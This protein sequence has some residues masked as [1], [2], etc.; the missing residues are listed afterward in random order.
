MIIEPWGEVLAKTELGEDLIYSKIDLARLHQL[1]LQFPC[2]K[3]HILE[4]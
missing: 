1:R 3:H 4:A 2:N